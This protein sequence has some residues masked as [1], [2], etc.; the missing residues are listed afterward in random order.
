MG[1]LQDLSFV[2]SQ[3]GF[4][5]MV[6]LEAATGNFCRFPRPRASCSSWFPPP[7]HTHSGNFPCSFCYVDVPGPAE[8]LGIFFS[9]FYY[10]G[11]CPGVKSSSSSSCEATGRR[12]TAARIASTSP[13]SW[14]PM[15]PPVPRSEP[16]LRR[17]NLPSHSV[18][19]LPPFLLPPPCLT[20]LTRTPFFLFGLYQ[21]PLPR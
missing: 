13:L 20:G 14:P 16:R 11:H 17:T 1:L 10:I 6:S 8:I 4:F 18:R 21:S 12:L 19:A 5:D 7:T 15:P 2:L 3:L 9:F